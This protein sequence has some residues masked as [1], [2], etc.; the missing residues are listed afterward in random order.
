M[1]FCVW[2]FCANLWR[3]H[4]IGFITDIR[5]NFHAIL[6]GLKGV[7]F[8]KFSFQTT[9]FLLQAHFRKKT[10]LGDPNCRLPLTKLKNR[11]NLSVRPTCWIPA[12]YRGV[13]GHFSSGSEG[14]GISARRAWCPSIAAC[15]EARFRSE[16]SNSSKATNYPDLPHCT[17]CPFHQDACFRASA[18]VA[19]SAWGTSR[20]RISRLLEWW[21]QWLLRWLPTRWRN[22]PS[23]EIG[24]TVARPCSTRSGSSGRYHRSY[25]FLNSSTWGRL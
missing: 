24:T 17:D 16:C 9:T 11:E 20:R 10:E 2:K 12:D 18:P 23:R 6:G 22:S 15:G 25:F 13:F 14:R 8:P 21:F 3:N 4:F 7:S 1:L 5:V 19:A